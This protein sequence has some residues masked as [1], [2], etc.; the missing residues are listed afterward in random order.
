MAAKK[1]K[2]SKSTAEVVSEENAVVENEA[3]SK[4]SKGERRQ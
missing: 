4:E 1:R 3:A 2:S